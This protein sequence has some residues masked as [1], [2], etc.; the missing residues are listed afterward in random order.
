MQRGRDQRR[1]RRPARPAA[2]GVA[3]PCTSSAD[4]GELRRDRR[5]LGGD[6]QRAP[7]AAERRPGDDVAGRRARAGSSS[8]GAQVQQLDLAAAV[9]VPDERGARAARVERHE[10]EVVVGALG[11]RVDGE[12]LAA[13]AQGDREQRR[14]LAARVGVH[15]ELP[16]GDAEPGVGDGGRRRAAARCGGPLRRSTSSSRRAPRRP[17][18]DH[19]APAVAAH[20][21]D[22][23]GGARCE[24]RRRAV[25][26]VDQAGL[27][28]ARPL[29]GKTVMPSW[30][31]P[32]D[33][34][35]SVT[36][37]AP[38]ASSRDLAA[39]GGDQPARGCA[40]R[41]T[42]RSAQA[43]QEPVGRPVQRLHVAVDGQRPLRLD[44]RA[45]VGR[46]RAP[47]RRAGGRRGRRS[48]PAGCRRGRAPG[49][50]RPWGTAPCAASAPT[51]AAASRR[52][53]K[54]DAP[55]APYPTSPSPAT[56]SPA[57]PPA[58]TRWNRGSS[59]S[60]FGS[61]SIASSQSRRPAL[62]PSRPDR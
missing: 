31:P 16:A 28:V 23:G 20:R 10:V 6:E 53:V 26:Q 48:R 43:S 5:A 8:A 19:R 34:A 18:P 57:A 7:V 51:A 44:D 55:P 29:A 45:A 50:R 60:V 61:A 47:P 27:P 35:P 30:R 15:V 36:A 59:A 24:H 54:S 38:G 52:S 1:A 49:G 56:T 46:Q 22:P 17:E 40:R 58:T 9:D 4:P 32:G 33:H 25:A 21:A 62:A 42:G 12:T 13:A 11:D 39:V 37:A 41:R 3:S 2:S 14:P